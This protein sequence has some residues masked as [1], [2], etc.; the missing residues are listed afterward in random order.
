M[1]TSNK[2]Q[3]LE[4]DEGIKSNNIINNNNNYFLKLGQTHQQKNMRL[5]LYFIEA[6]A[7]CNSLTK[8]N[9]DIIGETIDLEM[10]KSTGWTFEECQGAFTLGYYRPNEELLKKYSFK[11]KNIPDDE[12][13]NLSSVYQLDLIKRFDFVSKLQ[14]MSVLVK[15]ANE[16]YFKV[17]FS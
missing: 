11:E 3:F 5:K 8:I 13:S 15:N 9:W 14:R 17:Y 4:E 16:E 10:M 2:K 12:L 7:T 1:I 6:L